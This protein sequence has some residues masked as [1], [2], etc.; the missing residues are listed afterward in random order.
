[1]FRSPRAPRVKRQI[2]RTFHHLD[3]AWVFSGG[4]NCTAT[5]AKR[6]IATLCSVQPV[7]QFHAQFNRAAM[8]G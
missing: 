1:M 5:T 8:A 6:T 7:F 2:I 3:P 4:G